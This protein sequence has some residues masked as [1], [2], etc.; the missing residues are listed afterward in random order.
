[1]ANS[2]ARQTGN[3]K[4][5]SGGGVK[6]LDFGLARNERSLGRGRGFQV[7]SDQTV[8]GSSGPT[9]VYEFEAIK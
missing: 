4:F 5:A 7:A 2:I 9:S 8:A 3:I 1:L 6:I